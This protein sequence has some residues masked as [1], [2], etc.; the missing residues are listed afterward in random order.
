MAYGIVKELTGEVSINSTTSG[1]T[2]KQMTVDACLFFS[3]RRQAG[4]VYVVDSLGG[5]FWLDA[6]LV[7][8]TQV[9]P[10]SAVAFSGDARDL[11]E[12]LEGSFFYNV[13]NPASGGGLS[14]AE[15]GAYIAGG[16]VRLGTN[17]LIENTTI[18]GAFT[19]KIDVSG[20]DMTLVSN[21]YILIHNTKSETTNGV[22][23]FTRSFTAQ[24]TANAIQTIFTI[25]L[26]EL[27]VVSVEI[28]VQY[29]KQSI[30]GA[31]IIQAFG[32]GYR[33]TGGAAE[34]LNST[35]STTQQDTIS[36]QNPAILH[37]VSGNDYIIEIDPK[38]ANTTDFIIVLKYSIN[39]FT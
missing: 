20:A 12:L 11:Y 19:F 14:G 2:I 15:N 30:S 10:A 35:L 32:G 13:V 24:T 25:P 22:T 39:N 21:D 6:N 23:F 16:K 1:T 28:L 37:S 4:G 3:N 9:L 31:G 17:P 27:D 33:D 26:S 7:D 8:S 29:K 34:L 5:E 36:G 38:S 18:S